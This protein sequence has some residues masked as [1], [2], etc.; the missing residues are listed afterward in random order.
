MIKN[1]AKIPQRTKS[2]NILFLDKNKSSLCS[3][4]HENA[5]F[6]LI[7]TWSAIL[8]GFSN[9]EFGPFSMHEVLSSN[10]AENALCY[11]LAVSRASLNTSR[12]FSWALQLYCSLYNH[13]YG[14]HFATFLCLSWR[15]EKSSSGIS[16]ICNIS[17]SFSDDSHISPL[18]S[19]FF[20]RNRSNF[21]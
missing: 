8:V 4:L 12:I 15:L 7:F 2:K 11:L 18:N 3:H 9:E 21:I 6:Y 20:H 19:V 5:P 16:Q 14:M 17:P 10:K 13:C 1:I